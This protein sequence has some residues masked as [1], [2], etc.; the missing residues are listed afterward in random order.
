MVRSHPFNAYSQ[1]QGVVRAFQGYHAIHSL[2][3]QHVCQFLKKCM[4]TRTYTHTL[5]QAGAMPIHPRLRLEASRKRAAPSGAD[6][7]CEAE[8]PSVEMEKE[9]N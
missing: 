4:H 7:P 9:L 2:L 5:T 6:A 8:P 1:L 3:S